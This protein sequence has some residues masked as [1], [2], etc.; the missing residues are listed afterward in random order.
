MAKVVFLTEKLLI[1]VPRWS[2]VTLGMP[3]DP[4]TRATMPYG[5]LARVSGPVRIPGVALDNRGTI[6]GSLIFGQKIKISPDFGWISLIWRR[7]P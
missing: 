6:T 3:T 7:P 5:L 1:I 4:E 2:R